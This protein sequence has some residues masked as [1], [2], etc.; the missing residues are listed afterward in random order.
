MFIEQPIYATGGVMKI[1]I[2]AILAEIQSE[3]QKII[4]VDTVE[5]GRCL[6]IDGVVQTAERDHEIYDNHML[7]KIRES[8]KNILILGGGDGYIAQMALEK[9]KNVIIDIVD[10]DQLVV[11]GCVTYLNQNVFENKR[12]NLHVGDALL[13]MRESIQKYDGIVCDLTDVPAGSLNELESYQDFFSKVLN[14]ASLR[15]REDGWLSIQAGASDV[16][17]DFI[18]SVEV[19]IRMLMSRFGNAERVDVLI[20]S[21]G[22][23]CAFLYCKKS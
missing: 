16:S 18:N 17:N 5:F 20:P 2:K 4:F 6:M 13:Y 10:L 19:I 7:A 3:F 21:Y 1:P 15:M 14:L 22:E 8:D 11:D 23:K 12:V 9:N